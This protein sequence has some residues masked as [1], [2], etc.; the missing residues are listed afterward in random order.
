MT[1]LEEIRETYDRCFSENNAARRAL[2][3]EKKI[4]YLYKSKYDISN[5]ASKK[6][7]DTLRKAGRSKSYHFAT[8]LVNL[9]PDE[10]EAEA[11]KIR[12]IPDKNHRYYKV[13]FFDAQ[14]GSWKNPSEI[15]L[16]DKQAEKLAHNIPLNL[17][18]IKEACYN[19]YVDADKD[20]RRAEALEKTDTFPNGNGSNHYKFL[21]DW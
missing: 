17:S 18:E 21:R 20:M 12:L 1:I 11:N 3:K 9:I 16:T 2:T 6:F 19:H 14:D 13:S 4:E 10:N 5:E 7:I 8:Y 15:T